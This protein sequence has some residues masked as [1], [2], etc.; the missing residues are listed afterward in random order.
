VGAA[1]TGWRERV[2]FERRL[3]H[4]TGT[5]YPVPY[6]LGWLSWTQ[7][8]AL[9]LLSVATAAALEFLRLV[10]GLDHGPSRPRRSPCR[11]CGCSRSVTR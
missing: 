5:L 9:L 6:L 2:E 11:R 8:T 10:V 4:A 3:V 1:A 7:T